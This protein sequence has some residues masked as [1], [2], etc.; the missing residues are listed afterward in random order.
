MLSAVVFLVFFAL[1]G[2]MLLGRKESAF[3][4]IFLGMLV[5]PPCIYFTQKPLASTVV[6][7]CILRDERLEEPFRAFDGNF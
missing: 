3:G 6:P 5:F 7:L 1:F 4:W 2:A